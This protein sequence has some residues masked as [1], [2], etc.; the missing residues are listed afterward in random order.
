MAWILRGPGRRCCF[1]L[2]GPNGSPGKSTTIH[3]LS[4]LV[5]P[6][7]GRAWVAGRDVARAAV[8]VRGALGLV[9]QEPALDRT[10]TMFENL[11]TWPERCT[12]CRAG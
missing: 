11:R 10:L 6:D 7:Q 9:F 5:R 8:A 3:M 2:L 1:G 12:A 4:T